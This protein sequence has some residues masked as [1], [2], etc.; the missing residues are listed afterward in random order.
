M[1][2]QKLYR[3]CCFSYSTRLILK[4]FIRIKCHWLKCSY[5]KTNFY[6]FVVIENMLAVINI[7]GLFSRNTSGLC[8]QD[9]NIRVCCGSVHNLWRLKL[10]I[11][12]FERISNG[13]IYKRLKKTSTASIIITSG[14]WQMVSFSSMIMVD[15]LLDSMNWEVIHHPSYSPDLSAIFMWLVY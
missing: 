7:R 4:L 6:T 5:N 11:P 13:A 12:T 15:D 9:P 10:L 3:Y 1:C 2:F 8:N 14:S